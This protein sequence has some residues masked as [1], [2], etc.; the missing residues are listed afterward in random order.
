MTSPITAAPRTG[1]AIFLFSLGIFFFAVNDALGKWLVGTYPVGE[2]LLVRTGGAALFL[3][4]MLLRHPDSRRVPAQR[5][6]HLL[7]ILVMAGDTFAF[8]YATRSLP[9]ADVMTFYLAS[10]LFVTVL[11]VLFLR[12]RIGLW[13]IGAVLLGFIG[14]IIALHPTGP[15]LSAGAI[16]ALAGSLSFAAAMV[17]TRRLRHAH[18]L[19]LVAGQFIGAGVI[20][21]F[22]SGFDWVVPS[23]RDAALM[24]I[25]G[26][27]S[28]LCFLS[29]NQALRLAQASAL[30]PFQYTSIVWAV[31]LGWLIWGDLPTPA[32]CAGIA[33]IVASGA[34]V[35]L[36]E[37]RVHKEP[38][39]EAPVA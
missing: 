9:L 22:I 25:V 19:T 8:Y 10:P 14:V 38:I 32:M 7:R 17:I 4:P 12:E 6:L 13:R 16:V 15:T 18:W 31:L 27:V 30:A 5:W 34:I 37:R 28:M 39:L 33:L 23:P 20:G 36:R 24:V 26:I 29:I 1:T 3:A 11:A 35:W 21:A 2:I